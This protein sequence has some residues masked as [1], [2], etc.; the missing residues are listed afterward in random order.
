MDIDSKDE[1]DKISKV[2]RARNRTVMLTPEITGEVRNAIGKAEEDDFV[3]PGQIAKQSEKKLL[4]SKV[5]PEKTRIEKQSTGLRFGKSINRSRTTKISREELE[6]VIKPNAPKPVE[7]ADGFNLPQPS[8][9]KSFDPLTSLAPPSHS[10]GQQNQ[11]NPKSRNPI[12]QRAAVQTNMRTSNVPTQEMLL[13]NDSVVGQNIPST[14]SQA[15]NI[16][17]TKEKKVEHLSAYKGK[18]KIIGFLISYDKDE[19]GEVFHIR[20]GRKLITSRPTEH[21]QYMLI[22]HP[23]VSPLHAIIRTTKDNKIQ[24]MDQL[25]EHGTAITRLGSNEEVEV[26][27]GLETVEN[28]DILRIGEIRFLVFLLPNITF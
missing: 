5:E 1:E 8:V 22:E 19:N 6:S 14:N 13:P 9:P 27:G 16:Q 26:A 2:S 3:K 24:I 21:G 15:M 18:T 17:P 11:K 7:S 4:E 20:K 23:S 28:G 10:R 25:S 12:A